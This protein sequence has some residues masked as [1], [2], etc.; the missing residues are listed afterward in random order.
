MKKHG[1][2]YVKENENK[3]MLGM[4]SAL[5]GQKPRMI[6]NDDN[7]FRWYQSIGTKLIASFLI[8]V[9]FVVLIGAMSYG[10]ASDSIINNYKKSSQQAIEMTG[11]YLRFGLDSI[12]AAATE[13]TMDNNIQNYFFGV[14]NTDDNQLSVA[15]REIQ[16]ELVTKVTA[17]SFLENIYILSPYVQGMI[18]TM[19][20]GKEGLYQAF[21]DTQEGSRLNSQGSNA[22]WVGNNG[23][24]DNDLGAVNSDYSIRY[25]K[26]FTVGSAFMLLDISTQ[27]LRSIMDGLDF[28]EG[29]I[30]GIVT[31]DGSELLK[32]ENEKNTSQI[33]STEEFYKTALDSENTGGNAEVEYQGTDY[34][35]LYSKVGDTGVMLCALIPKSLILKEV[36]SIKL[37]SVLL[38]L[39]ASII[40][41]AIGILMSTGIQRIIRYITDVLKE[42]SKGNLAVSLTVNRKDEFSLLSRE[43]NNTINNMRG[44]IDKITKQSGVVTVSST[45]V[46]DASLVFAEATQGITESMN[47]IQMGVNQQAQDSED[48]LAQMD[49]LS[50]KIGLVTGKTDEINFIAKGTKESI[51]QGMGSVQTLS[52][53]T[54]STSR[55]AD[56]IIQSIQEL[57][58]KSKSIGKIT[59]AINSIA[60]E[61][62][63]LSLNASIEAARAGAAG[64]GFSVVAQEIRKLADQ[65]V[66]AVHDIETLVK[67]IQSRTKEAVRTAMEADSIVREQVEAVQNTEEAFHNMNHYVEKLVDN[68]DHIYESIHVIE[69]AKDKTQSSIESISAVAQQTAAAS[70]T[71][72]DT[73]NHQL[74]AIATLNSLSEELGGNAQALS[75]AVD[76]F[77]VE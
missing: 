45:K 47:E 62:N 57:E 4:L 30:I 65:S 43:I 26:G 52:V 77:I 55:I 7:S 15:K 13:Y 37:L 75:E 35:Y 9:C 21:L 70:I 36:S 48:C 63:L 66:Q 8:P 67:D 59:A 60:N 40:A 38:V 44:L 10:K 1:N 73:I 34:L 16:T 19:G 6:Q 3:K 5:V 18:S 76:Q 20:S 58:G 53:K 12:D 32:Q 31:E 23:T 17:D 14:Y 11:E 33:F 41:I 46:R 29:S 68:V 56:Q 24:F 42:V 39:I 27:T 50:D 61:T 2:R 72:G 69:S 49:D 51:N 74:E 71:V 25:V 64:S 28:G 54:Q 22:Y